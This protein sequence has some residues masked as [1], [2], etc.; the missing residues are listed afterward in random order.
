L[1]IWDDWFAVVE[2]HAT[3]EAIEKDFRFEKV[4]SFEKKD[5]WGN[6]RHTVLFRYK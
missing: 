1:L 2:G 3:L 4:A 5:Y 6:T